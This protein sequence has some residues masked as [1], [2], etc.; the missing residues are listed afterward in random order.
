MNFT[1]TGRSSEGAVSGVL[2][3]AN[4]GAVAD[5]LMARG[6]TLHPPVARRL[7]N[8]LAPKLLRV[9]RI[10]DEVAGSFAGTTLR[11]AHRAGE[12]ALVG[13]RATQIPLT[14]ERL[15]ELQREPGFVLIRERGRSALD[16]IDL[17]QAQRSDCGP[18][19]LVRPDGYIAFAAPGGDESREVASLRAALERARK[20]S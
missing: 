10:R 11:Y 14:Q 2:E 1:Y 18:A 5:T 19:V 8:L 3:G 20:W 13:T 15:T 16:V 12:S 7:R 9:P 4:A 17:H 6:V